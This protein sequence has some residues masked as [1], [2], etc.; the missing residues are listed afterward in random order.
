MSSGSKVEAENLER[1]SSGRKLCLTDLFNEPDVF[2]KGYLL[3]KTLDSEGTEV[4]MMYHLK[5]QM[6][7]FESK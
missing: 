3:T 5:K 6:L 7:M 2:A 4:R 1:S